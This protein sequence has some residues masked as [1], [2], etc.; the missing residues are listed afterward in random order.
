MAVLTPSCPLQDRTGPLSLLPY[1][2]TSSPWACSCFLQ[3]G[4]HDAFRL[5]TSIIAFPAAASA[6]SVLCGC[7]LDIGKVT[8]FSLTGN[9]LKISP[10]G[11]GT[12]SARIFQVTYIA[13]SEQ[14][15][16]P[17]G[18]DTKMMYF[19]TPQDHPY[20]LVMA[21]LTGVGQSL[22]QLCWGVLEHMVAKGM[23]STHTSTH[24]Q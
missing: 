23:P 22:L 24:P 2:L 5:P 14:K 19:L 15:I 11:T 13:S 18:T 9:L 21:S 10:G 4:S 1:L 3:H 12:D 17:L 6:L 16:L 7:C 8:F 20:L